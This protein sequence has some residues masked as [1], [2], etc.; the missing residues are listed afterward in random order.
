MDELIAFLRARLDDDERIAK[1][2]TPGPWSVND[3]S[4]AESIRAADG[5]EVVAGGR[6]GGEAPV[7]ESTEDALHIAAH[8]PARVQL[9]VESGRQA[10]AHYER[11][12]AHRWKHLDYELAVGAVEVQLK[13]RAL[14]YAG[15]PDYRE[16]WTS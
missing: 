2:A 7:F 9:E 4:F 8:D 14:A 13:L 5:T 3:E 6:W 1:A 12:A 11:V 10:I 15:H 16:A